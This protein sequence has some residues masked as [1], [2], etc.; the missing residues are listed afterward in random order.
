MASV[1]SLFPSNRWW[2][3]LPQCISR[4]GVK[5]LIPEID[6][7]RW[8]AIVPVVLQHLA[9]RL[10]HA[11]V[12]LQQ[13][14]QGDAFS[15]LAGR[16]FS[17]VFLFF[18]LSGFIISLPFYQAAKSG[19]QSPSLSAYLLR[20]LSRLEP[21]FLIIM[22]MCFI[23]YLG[24]KRELLT[25]DLIHFLAAITYTHGFWFEQYN[26]INPVTWS[27]EVEIQFYLLAP[28]LLWLLLHLKSA[29]HR[30]WLT[31]F[32]IVMI[33]ILQH[34]TMAYLVPSKLHVWGH[35]HLFMAGLLAADLY[36]NPAKI[37]A[38]NPLTAD[39]LFT[40]ALCFTFLLRKH[41]AI[42]WITYPFWL[43]MLLY[44]SFRSGLW[45]RVITLPWITGLGG[46]CY[47]IYLLHLPLAEAWMKLGKY[48]IIG[49]DF[50]INFLLQ[51]LF[52]IPLTVFTSLLVFLYL[53]R[54][55][56]V[57]NWPSLVKQALFPPKHLLPNDPS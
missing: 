8:L 4:P 21:P 22:M 31:V 10:Q 7:L 24:V 15:F 17:G 1:S 23:G 47:S 14:L 5:K 19:L 46:M 53:E 2:A 38:I 26:P 45:R 50:G 43:F 36:V 33:G 35:L 28:L 27:L 30:Q 18:A 44:F 32:L 29:K 20:R 16:G 34:V 11:S 54:P 6:G 37:R 13:P 41:E 48:L 25:E 12:Q 9:E 57:R 39:I 40:L 52:F 42:A 51:S 3:N 56:M 49:N 55:C